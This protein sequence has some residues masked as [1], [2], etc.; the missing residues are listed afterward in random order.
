MPYRAGDW[1]YVEKM[2]IARHVSELTSWDGWKHVVL[3]HAKDTPSCLTHVTIRG[4]GAGF[5][6]QLRHALVFVTSDFPNLDEFSKF[7]SLT[8]DEFCALPYPPDHN[9]RNRDPSK[10]VM[11]LVLDTSASHANKC[12]RTPLMGRYVLIKLLRPAAGSNID[13]GYI[14]L[15]G[16]EDARNGPGYS[17]AVH[18]VLCTRLL[19]KTISRYLLCILTHSPYTL[20]MVCYDNS[21]G[22]LES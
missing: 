15:S 7:D 17:S 1:E 16:Y 4:P 10:P 22:D 11:F 6:A 12:L 5:T 3:K 13:V 21:V 14:G 9:K 8:T 2:G 19:Q 18:D 20:C